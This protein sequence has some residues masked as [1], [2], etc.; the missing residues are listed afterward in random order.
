[1][2]A[3][4]PG[5]G[6]AG[7]GARLA[8]VAPVPASPPLARP[9]RARGAAAR[10][11]L[12]PARRVEGDRGDLA[13]LGGGVPRRADHGALAGVKTRCIPPAPSSNLLSGSPVQAD[14]TN[15]S[16]GRLTP[17][18]A[19]WPVPRITARHNFDETVAATRPRAHLLARAPLG[20]AAEQPSP[21]RGSLPPPDPGAHAAPAARLQRAGGGPDTWLVAARASLLDLLA[22]ARE[23]ARRPRKR[24]LSRAEIRRQAR[25]AFAGASAL[26]DEAAAALR[27]AQ[28]VMSKPR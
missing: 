17:A 7:H 18:G 28:A 6:H 25:E 19:P 20:S 11:D 15:R 8:G 26:L 12:G 13:G 23:G 16:P 22:A 10:R 3:P 9:G 2:A 27:E 14:P 5:P 24:V 21:R 1:M 4:Y